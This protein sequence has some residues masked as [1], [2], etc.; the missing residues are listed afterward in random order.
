MDPLIIG[1]GI[2]LLGT[3][4]FMWSLFKNRSENIKAKLQSEFTTSL[5]SVLDEMKANLKGEGD[6]ETTPKRLADVEARLD[7]M[8]L[9]WE[10]IKNQV[11]RHLQMAST[12]LSRA[13]KKEQDLEFED[14]QQ[15]AQIQM[16]IEEPQPEEAQNGPLTLDQLGSYIR[17]QGDLPV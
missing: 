1:S 13:S 10:E 8:E 14:D 7:S 17:S 16:P 5:A 6:I 4:V 3:G 12:R 9:K 15:E 11:L 2:G